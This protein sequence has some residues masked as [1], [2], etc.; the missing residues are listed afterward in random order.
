MKAL[1]SIATA[2][3]LIGFLE[4]LAVAQPRSTDRDRLVGAWKMVALEQP[5]PDGKINRTECCGMFVFTRDG[6]LS[7]QVMQREPKPQT[8][9][10]QYSQG[11]YEAS[12]GSYAVD[13]NNHTFTFHVEGALVR[14]L[15]G[16]DLQRAYE[17][18]G[19]RL[20]VK[21]ARADEHWRVIWEHY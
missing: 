18:Q 14:S 5:G 11:G 19:D 6:H 17:F 8:A 2:I 10:E 4:A 7:V 16:K 15:I 21:P 3:L 20:I 1:I 13:E 9:A 12:Y